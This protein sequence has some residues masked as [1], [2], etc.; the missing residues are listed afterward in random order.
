MKFMRNAEAARKEQNDAELRRLHRELHGEESQSEAESEVGRRKFGQSEKT[1]SKP[2]AKPLPKNEFEEAPGSG[3]EA[4]LDQDVDIVVG[5]PAKQKSQAS[6]AKTAVRPSS[7]SS[8]VQK[9]QESTEEEE[10]PWLVQTER[11]N[12][13]RNLSDVQETVDISLDDDQ[14]PSNSAVNACS[15]K[16]KATKAA[17]AKQLGADDHDSDDDNVPVLLKNHDLVKRAFAGDEV[18]QD[19]DQEKLDTIEDEGDKV[20]DNTLP[21]WGSWAGEGISKRQQKRQ[22]RNLTTVEG[23]KPEQRKDAKLQ[24]VIINEKRVKKVSWI[25]DVHHATLLTRLF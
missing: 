9:Q 8:G 23:V 2:R 10:N 15:K 20:V 13:R 22:K 11:N 3:D 4:D 12:R 16:G 24:R 7:K 14:K 5:P 6:G 19:F 17:P 1:D 18:V 21:G 25:P